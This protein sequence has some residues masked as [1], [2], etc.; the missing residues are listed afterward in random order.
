MKIIFKTTINCSNF[1]AQNSVKLST[2]NSKQLHL[3][4]LMRTANVK[5]RLNLKYFA[6]QSGRSR[7]PNLGCDSLFAH[8]CFRVGHSC[9]QVS[10]RFC[11]WADFVDACKAEVK[12]L[13]QTPTERT[14]VRERPIVRQSCKTQHAATFN[15]VTGPCFSRWYFYWKLPNSC[16]TFTS[17]NFDRV[18]NEKKRICNH[19]RRKG[20]QGLK[21]SAKKVV[22]PVS[23]GKNQISPLLTPLGK[24]P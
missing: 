10:R 6:T 12:R 13:E 22:F 24:I 8:P 21:F 19:G 5:C 2:W 4:C 7:D 23:S 15:A 11:I 14:S 17:T 16:W 20:G 1:L 3:F 18:R 9:P